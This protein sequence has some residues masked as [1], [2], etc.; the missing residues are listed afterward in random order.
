LIFPVLV[1]YSEYL[2]ASQASIGWLYAVY[3]GM[4]LFSTLFVGK[5][6]DKYGR[7]AV[8][9]Y[10][11]IGAILSFVGSAL[12]RTFIEFAICRGVSGLF[13]GTIGNAYAYVSDIVPE[14]ERPKYIS[15]VTATLS[16]CF[17]IGPIIGGGFAAIDIR[18]PFVAAAGMATFELILVVCFVKNPQNDQNDSDND[19]SLRN[20]SE[21]LLN[22]EANNPLTHTEE[23]TALINKDGEDLC[24]S[25]DDIIVQVDF[26]V[27]ILN[28]MSAE[29]ECKEE[30]KIVE[31]RNARIRSSS[32]AFLPKLTA[33]NA[34]I[35]HISKDDQLY[36][37][38]INS[39]GDVKTLASEKVPLVSPWRNPVALLIGGIGV[40]L[41]TGTYCGMAILVPFMLMESDF[42]IIAK[43]DDDEISSHDSKHLSLVIGLLLTMLGT[44]QVAGMLIL[45]PWFNKHIGLLFTGAVGSAVY[46]ATFCCLVFVHSLSSLYPIVI[47]LAIGYSLCRPVFPAFLGVIAPKEKSGDYQAMSSAFNQAAWIFAVLLTQFWSYSHIGAILYSGGLSILNATILLCYGIY[48]C[49][50]PETAD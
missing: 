26:P 29:I 9:L 28:D 17:V 32:F 14:I 13:T 27:V 43:S 31:E 34:D 23:S 49:E 47:G 22:S 42:G 25:N 11:C 15:Y 30:V 8:F 2:H 37:N 18:A 35:E 19:P 44:V 10:C 50:K 4:A 40:F 36:T 38:G 24:I 7:R 6:S 21:P 3:S 41:S 45:F 33:N 1:T 20:I 16:T 39:G 46:G 5:L 12:S 48:V